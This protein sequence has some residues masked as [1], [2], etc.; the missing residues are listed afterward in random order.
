MISS[1]SCFKNISVVFCLTVVVVWPSFVFAESEPTWKA[2]IIGIGEYK[3]RQVPDLR[4]PVADGQELAQVLAGQYGFEVTT[5]FDQDATWENID[6]SLY[7]LAAESTPND[8]ILIYYGG[9]GDIDKKMGEGWWYPSDTIPKNRQTF[10]K[11]SHIRSFISKMK[12]RHVLL[13]SDSCFAGTLFGD[14]RSAGVGMSV[15]DKYHRR[16]FESKS[17]LGLTSGGNEP[18]MD[19]GN[20][21]HSI[22]AYYLLKF[23]KKSEKEVFSAGELFTDIAPII[24]NNSEQKPE[25]LPILNTGHEK[26]EFVF[27]RLG[28]E[29]EEYV[30]SNTIGQATVQ[31]DGDYHIWFIVF[32]IAA[33]C[34]LGGGLIVPKVRQKRQ[35]KELARAI[36]QRDVEAVE[37]IVEEADPKD[38]TLL[39]SAEML[40]SPVAGILLEN[41]GERLVVA[42]GPRQGLGRGDAWPLSISD[43]HISRRPHAWLLMGEESFSINS[44]GGEVKVNGEEQKSIR[45]NQGDKI[46]LGSVTVL[47]VEKV[48][49]GVGG[50]L[51]IQAGPEKG[52]KLILLGDSTPLSWLTDAERQA[53]KLI[54]KKKRPTLFI[55][56]NDSHPLPLQK[57]K[58][59]IQLING[60]IL[61]LGHREWRVTLL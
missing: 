13:I 1:L 54:W 14:Y 37:K 47:L 26:G 38:E 40:Q 5:L 4:T 50:V 48:V 32:G 53:G 35:E 6:R 21:G 34:I 56:S 27:V 29:L 7:N 24:T 2:L 43:P 16:L 11:N 45:L 46:S 25:F 17:R 42:P 58:S 19:G 52:K 23:L 51:Y 60:D 41:Q 28:Y 33:C 8:S 55:G 10:I 31:K 61:V 12:A 3:H 20:D 18:V 49:P 39:L 57:D 59:E 36:D 44:D 15:D 22:F 9:H 30:S